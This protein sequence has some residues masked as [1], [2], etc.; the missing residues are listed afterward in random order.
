MICR[1]HTSPIPDPLADPTRDPEGDPFV[2]PTTSRSGPRGRRIKTRC[3]AAGTSLQRVISVKPCSRRSTSAGWML[4][5]VEIRNNS[6]D[7]PP[8][9]A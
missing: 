7:K 6:A 5:I 1:M 8:C 3:E 4:P 2:P 9:P